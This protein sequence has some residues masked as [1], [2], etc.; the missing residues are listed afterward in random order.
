MSRIGKAPILIPQGVTVEITD[1][2]V[3]IKGLKGNLSFKYPGDVVLKREGDKVI[4]EM[5]GKSKE[6]PAL[7]GTTR[8]LIA[9]MIKGVTEGYEKKLELVGVGYR[10][11]SVSP[12]EISLTV[13][14]SH[15]VDF[16][17]PEGVELKVEDNTHITVSGFDK[18]LVGL[19]AAKIRKIRKPEPYKGKGIKYADEVV[20]RKPGKAGKV[21][22]G[23][24]A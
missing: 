11:K 19:T 12:R 13:G 23:G 8:A 24:A 21:G 1:S 17:S 4:V 9:N 15:P 10:V 20:R 16:T 7:W 6:S 14:Y 5:I 18:H 22:S 3:V 2:E